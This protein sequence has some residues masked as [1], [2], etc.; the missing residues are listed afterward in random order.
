MKEKSCKDE[1]ETRSWCYRV[2]SDPYQVLAEAFST[3]GMPHLRGFIKK[4]LRYSEAKKVY[5]EN[6]P[7]DVLLYMRVVRSLIMAAHVLKEKKN[8]PIDVSEHDAFNKNY[9]CS[10]Y[11][12]DNEWGQFPRFLSMKEYCNPYRVF[13]KLFKYET[14]DEWLHDWEEIVDCALSPCSGELE[15]EMIAVYTRLCKLVEA[16]HLINVREVNHI[17]GMLKNRVVIS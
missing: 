5:R 1:F 8:G 12:M 15:I 9:Y 17:G 7:S 10:H 13:D 14:L 6:S 16:A 3:A 4:A 2:V 11:Q